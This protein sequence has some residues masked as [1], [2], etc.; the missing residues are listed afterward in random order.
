MTGSSA[1]ENV[2]IG[3]NGWLHANWLGAFYPD[4]LPEDWQLD[5]YSNIF[6]SVL[7]PMQDW[8]SWG[9][10]DLEELAD[11]VEDEFSFYFAMQGKLDVQQLKQLGKV[12]DALKENAKGLLVWSE[13]QQLESNIANLPVTLLSS[14]YH[15]P[16]WNWQYNDQQLSGNP[17]GYLPILP[18]EGRDQA[19]IMK[20]FVASLPESHP[21]APMIVG[22]DQINMDHVINLK[23]VTELLGY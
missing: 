15:L 1:L 2:Q 14:K 3:T 10:D 19:A 8:M 13:D 22:G 4:D 6:K 21:A 18:V 17:L 11:C 7:V 5:Y 23:T 16:G 9:C 12:V 20:S